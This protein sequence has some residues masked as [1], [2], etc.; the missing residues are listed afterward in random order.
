MSFSPCLQL[1]SNTY[2]LL[3][4][5]NIVYLNLQDAWSENNIIIDEYKLDVDDFID[6]C[7]A[8]F[9]KLIE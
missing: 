9:T 4:A 2:L 5:K 7:I 6:S 3:K 1:G 8:K